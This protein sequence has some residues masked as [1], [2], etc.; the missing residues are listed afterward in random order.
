LGKR[1]VDE[2]DNLMY[3]LQQVVIRHVNLGQGV[4]TGLG[5]E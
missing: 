2:T 4:L 3:W 1:N 5:P